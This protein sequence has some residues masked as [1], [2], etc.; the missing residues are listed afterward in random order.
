MCEN[1]TTAQYQ[2]M[3]KA[4]IHE[5]LNNLCQLFKGFVELS[6]GLPFNRD[7]FLIDNYALAEVIV[8]ANKR[9]EYYRYFHGMKINQYK[10]AALH[11]YWILKLRPFTVINREYI[12]KHLRDC[13]EL[14]E[15][16]AINLIYSELAHTMRFTKSDLEKGPGT[17]HEK[18]MYSF[19]YR[20]ISID[21]MLLLVESVNLEVLQRTFPEAL[22]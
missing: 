10:S 3:P 4:E 2:G 15:A 6:G 16:F 11:A 12:V 8:R 22:G 1:N 20:S 14:N 21:A 13:A 5:A 17:Y 9:K 18:L 7:N 19:R